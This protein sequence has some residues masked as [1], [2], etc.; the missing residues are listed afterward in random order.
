[1]PIPES[2]S[3]SMQ[4]RLHIKVAMFHDFHPMIFLSLEVSSHLIV[5]KIIYTFENIDMESNY[6]NEVHFFSKQLVGRTHLRD[7]TTNMEGQK[8]YLRIPAHQT[9]I[10]NK[11]STTKITLISV[12][13]HY[14]NP[15]TV[16]KLP[17]FLVQPWFKKSADIDM[18]RIGFD[19]WSDK[20]QKFRY[21]TISDSVIGKQII[22]RRK[23][24][25]VSR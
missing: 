18:Y 23:P 13:R 1:M 5:Y 3:V 2:V 16:I 10:N 12:S 21:R 24:V 4:P 6:Q 7:N 25:N 11:K 20:D 9:F 17:Q 15:P 19:S 22:N 14:K 8:D